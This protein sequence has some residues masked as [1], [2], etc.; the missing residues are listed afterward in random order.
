M[1]VTLDA[2]FIDPQRM[3]LEIATQDG[4]PIAVDSGP[5][6]GDGGAADPIDLV[7]AALA[8]CTSMDVASILRKKRQPVD[9]YDLEVDGEEATEHPQMFVAIT[10]EHVIAGDVDPEAVRRSIELSATRYC[11]VSALLSKGVTIEHRY[12]LT[13]RDGTEHAALVVVTGPG[14]APKA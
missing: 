2:R 5:P 4:H 1:T 11:P 8:G 6:D 7:L 3:R 10:V 9:R 14:D 12:R 13:R